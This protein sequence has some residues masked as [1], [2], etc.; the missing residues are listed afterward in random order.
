[1][2]GLSAPEMPKT[3]LP[4]VSFSVAEAHELIKRKSFIL[5]HGFG[6]FSS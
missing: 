3:G 1:M 6:G 2:D 4:P 5:A